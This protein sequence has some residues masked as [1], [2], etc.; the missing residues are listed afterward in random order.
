MHTVK[1]Y[2]LD[3]MRFK[4]GDNLNDLERCTVTLYAGAGNVLSTY[5]SPEGELMVN[6]EHMANRTE[7]ITYTFLLVPPNKR[8]DLTHCRFINSA[9]EMKFRQDKRYINNLFHVYIK[10]EVRYTR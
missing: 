5:F 4:T 8:F 9:V 1:S 3:L 7:V 2:E 6:I 10:D